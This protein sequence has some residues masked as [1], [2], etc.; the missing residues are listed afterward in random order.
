[1]RYNVLSSVLWD[2]G[3]EWDYGSLS[4]QLL[5]PTVNVPGRIQ[6]KLL[7]INA[8]SQNDEAIVEDFVDGA[9]P[10]GNKLDTRPAGWR[11]LLLEML[12]LHFKYLAAIPG[13]KMKV[14]GC[15]CNLGVSWLMWRCDPDVGSLWAR[16]RCKTQ[17]QLLICFSFANYSMVLLGTLGTQRMQADCEHL[18]KLGFWVTDDVIESWLDPSHSAMTD[19]VPSATQF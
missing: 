6:R 18:F 19:R 10:A 5:Q 1:M 14:C 4:D 16:C 2:M 8:D 9:T 17:P 15:L 3:C 13:M 7:K 11:T 12:V